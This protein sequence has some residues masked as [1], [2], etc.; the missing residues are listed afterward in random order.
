MKAP[1][2]KLCGEEHWDR[3]C[4]KFRK[5][6]PKA[7]LAKAVEKPAKE[8]VRKSNLKTKSAAKPKP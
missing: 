7:A 5:A 2:C 6:G 1:K 3:V 4:P 8:K